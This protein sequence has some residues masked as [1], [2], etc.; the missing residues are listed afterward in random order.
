MFKNGVRCSYESCLETITCYEHQLLHFG[1]NDNHRHVEQ[2]ESIYTVG[3]INH[4]N[5]IK[6]IHIV[7]L[8]AYLPL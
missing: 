6:G 3:S 7:V 1:L 8:S 2:E 4:R 5:K